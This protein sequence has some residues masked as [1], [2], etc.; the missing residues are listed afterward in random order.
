MQEGYCDPSGQG[1]PAV[2]SGTTMPMTAAARWWARRSG[3]PRPHKATI[4]RWATRGVRGHRLRAE[5]RGGRWFVSVAALEDFHRVLNEPPPRAADRSAGPI[6]VAAVAR[7]I[8]ELD[9]EA[10]L[11]EREELR[12][13]SR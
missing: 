7:V 2:Q 3:T 1:K 6:R 8:Q 11:I 4:L 9:A 12:R 13:A 5:R 10:G